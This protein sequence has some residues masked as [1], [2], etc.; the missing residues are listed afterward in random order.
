LVPGAGLY[1][2]KN[3]TQTHMVAVTVSPL[4]AEPSLRK[5]P[6][7]ARVACEEAA[8]LGHR[9]VRGRRDA[10]H[11]W[12]RVKEIGRQR[13]PGKRAS[14]AELCVQ[15]RPDAG[16]DLGRP[17]RLSVGSEAS[18]TRPPAVCSGDRRAARCGRTHLPSGSTIRRCAA[19][20]CCARCDRRWQ[21][22]LCQRA[23]PR[24]HRPALTK[25][26]G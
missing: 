10:R 19:R 4:R 24:G 22:D 17:I 8:A 20:A 11:A 26:P 25:Y 1:I 14:A 21:R 7:A 2:L 9:R 6:E 5:L 18:S 15:H 16:E 13:P 23:Q 12:S 3:G